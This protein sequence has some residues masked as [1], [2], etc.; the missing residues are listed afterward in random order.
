MSQQDGEDMVLKGPQ[1]P[2]ERLV[3]KVR[4]ERYIFWHQFTV[5]INFHHATNF[6]NIL[7]HGCL[8]GSVS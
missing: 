3:R 7:F 2:N 1:S 5:N 4:K 8:G 6:R